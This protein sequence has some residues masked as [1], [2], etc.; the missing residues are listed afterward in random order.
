MKHSDEGL[1]AWQKYYNTRWQHFLCDWF[2]MHAYLYS[3][4]STAFSIW[5]EKVSVCQCCGAP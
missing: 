5:N 3:T 2:G 1:S 4:H